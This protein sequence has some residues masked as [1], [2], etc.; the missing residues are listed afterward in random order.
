MKIFL[1]LIGYICI[2]FTLSACSKNINNPCL[3]V[4][5]KKINFTPKEQ[6]VLFGEIHGTNESPETFLTL[7][8]KQLIQTDKNLIISLE[9]HSDLNDRLTIYFNTNG[10]NDA[11]MSLLEHSFWTRK[12]QSD[13]AL[14]TPNVNQ[15]GRSSLAMLNMLDDFRKVKLHYPERIRFELIDGEIDR[16]KNIYTSNNRNNVM[17]EN[18][19]L[20]AKENPN[21]LIY[22][23]IG[24]FHN[25]KNTYENL[26]HLA[27]T[28]KH[29][30]LPY[31]SVNL[32]PTGGTSWTCSGACGISQNMELSTK[33]IEASILWQKK[34]GIYDDVIPIGNTTAS[35]P[36]T[37]LIEELGR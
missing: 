5:V 8:C 16:F 10:S 9:I 26:S 34:H 13:L 14:L 11:K 3:S 23:L 27:P 28:A 4:P 25:Q 30:G 36:A 7:S 19:R 21:K 37:E 15:D 35:R 22:T 12:T 20:L 2:A 17:A 18:L 31:H 6:I 33:D 24:N 1:R 32:M 29:I